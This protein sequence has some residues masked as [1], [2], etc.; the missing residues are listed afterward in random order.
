MQLP[1]ATVENAILSAELSVHY[2]SP[3]RQQRASIIT[4][5]D[6]LVL[7]HHQYFSPTG[8]HAGKLSMLIGVPNFALPYDFLALV[9][10]FPELKFV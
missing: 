1:A 2:A 4:I 10:N 6:R 5:T 8:N 9:L 3:I 7:H